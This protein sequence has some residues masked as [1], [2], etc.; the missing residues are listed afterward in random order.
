MSNT[1]ISTILM[2]LTAD[3]TWELGIRSILRDHTLTEDLFEAMLYH[4]PLSPIMRRLIPIR[5]QQIKISRTMSTIY[6]NLQS[7]EEKF[8][9]M[10][11]K[12]IQ[13]SDENNEHQDKITQHASDLDE[14]SKQFNKQLEVYDDY[15]NTFHDDFRDLVDHCFAIEKQ[16]H[17]AIDW[18]KDRLYLNLKYNLT[19][20]SQN[21]FMTLKPITLE[22]LMTLADSRKVDARLVL[23]NVSKKTNELEILSTD[24]LKKLMIIQVSLQFY[25]DLQLQAH[26]STIPMDTIISEAEKALN[27]NPKIIADL[28]SLYE[29]KWPS[30][31]ID[32]ILEKCHSIQQNI[33]GISAELDKHPVKDESSQNE[34]APEAK[35]KPFNIDEKSVGQSLFTDAQNIKL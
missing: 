6:K 10:D 28:Q 33:S 11:F 17:L 4:S 12:K 25:D 24:D 1:N 16:Y 23:E 7:C 30:K 31:N 9:Q 34:D 18:V 27:S 35:I 13:S 29:N 5:H 2:L 32:D 3:R 8:D 14:I 20:R 21:V 15:L 19:E 22:S 26:E